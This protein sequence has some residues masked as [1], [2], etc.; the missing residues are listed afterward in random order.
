MNWIFVVIQNQ[1]PVP[2]LV[3]SLHIYHPML[4]S[5]HPWNGSSS[6]QLFLRIRGE[7]IKYLFNRLSVTRATVVK[8]CT[9]TLSSFWLL[10]KRNF[11][12][13]IA[14]KHGL[15]LIMFDIIFNSI[16]ASYH[17]IF[18][19]IQQKIHTYY[20]RPKICNFFSQ[21]SKGAS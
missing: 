7:K 16:L 11:K 6:H 3:V 20:S 17:F 13:F 5:V 18:Y 19:F 21:N 10:S 12:H 15:P 2:F 14:K 1:I 9:K 4:Y 8:S